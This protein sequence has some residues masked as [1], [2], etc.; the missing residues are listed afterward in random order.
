M[1][2][3]FAYNGFFDNDGGWYSAVLTGPG[4]TVF[5][6]SPVFPGDN[7]ETFSG[8]LPAGDYQL[9]TY[10]R[11][12]GNVSYSF[13]IVPAPASGALLGFAGVLAGRRRR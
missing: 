6:S 9:V 7:D 10:G 4:G 1:P 11:S 5:A 12:R 2:Y 13:S 8:V 3:E